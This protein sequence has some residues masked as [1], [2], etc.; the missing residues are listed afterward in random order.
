MIVL[1]VSL[2][3]KRYYLRRL[4]YG[5]KTRDKSTCKSSYFG[6]LMSKLSRKLSFSKKIATIFCCNFSEQKSFNTA[7]IFPAQSFSLCRTR[8]ESRGRVLS[9]WGARAHH[10]SGIWRVSAWLAA[11]QRCRQRDAARND[12]RKSC[13]CSRRSVD[14]AACIFGRRRTRR[15]CCRR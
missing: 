9:M 13:R 11:C 10:C 3:I 6:S 7:A 5:R 14:A 4:L 2:R 15:R 8:Q 1:E 12:W